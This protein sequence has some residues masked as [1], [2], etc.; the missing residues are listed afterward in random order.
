MGNEYLLDTHSPTNIFIRSK[1]CLIYLSI[2]KT[3][4]SES[5][6]YGLAFHH[7]VKEHKD[8]IFSKSSELFPNVR[9]VSISKRILALSQEIK[10]CIVCSNAHVKNSDFCSK[11]CRESHVK[12][13]TKNAR[14]EKF[15]KIESEGGL[16]C[17]ICNDMCSHD[18]KSHIISAHKITPAEYKNEY[19]EPTVSEK[20]RDNIS[21]R[22][23]GENNPGFNHGGRLSPF[24]EKFKK[25]NDGSANYTKEDV[26]NKMKETAKKF[27][28]NQIFKLEYYTSRGL[29]EEEAK[30]KRN[31]IT[32]FSLEK[33]IKKYGQEKG[34]DVWSARQEKWQSTLNAKPPEEIER[35]KRA[36]LANGVSKRG[37][38]KISQELFVIIYDEIKTVYDEIYF[39]TLNP[40][41]KTIEKKPNN[42]FY[43]YYYHKPRRGYFFDFFVKDVNKI[44]EFDGEYW[45]NQKQGIQERDE[46][47]DIFLNQNGFEVLR[48]RENDFRQNKDLTVNECVKWINS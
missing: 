29:S 16:W 27:P 20:Y 41:T 9:F 19:N 38:S 43:E 45:H 22:V 34:T 7:L 32:V 40:I 47:R 24:S 12:A 30:I 21:I 5:S 17:K 39:A 33:C 31:E 46:A 36:R 18:L 42:R 13:K 48:V 28:E 2:C 26:C 11:L 4:V 35:I 3:I 1:E 44:I 10:Y 6:K 23:S 14:S 25:Y 15:K 8:E 37:Y